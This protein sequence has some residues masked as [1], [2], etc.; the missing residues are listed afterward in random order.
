MAS[1][2]R[3]MQDRS[4]H[5]VAVTP[6]SAL[7]ASSRARVLHWI[8]RTG[9]PAAHFVT[10]SVMNPSSLLR[11]FARAHNSPVL[12]GRHAHP[13]GQ[14]VPESILLK[15]GRP[16]V[17]DIDDGLPFDNGR[18]PNH[19]R[20]WKPLVAKSRIA[21]R[22]AS[23]AD[24]VIAGN[25]RL[26]EWSSTR[27]SDVVLIP[28]CVEP[29]AYQQ[30]TDFAPRERKVI[31][32]IGSSATEVHLFGIADALNRAYERSPFRLEI[33]SSGDKPL[34]PGL[35]RFAYRIAWSQPTQHTIL[36]TWDA[37]LMPLPDHL[38]EQS[39]CA[40]KLL[41]YGAASIPAIGS[42]VGASKT[43]LEKAG[44]PTPRTSP[45]W[46]DALVDVLELPEAERRALG[47]QARTVVKIAYSY[48]AWE[49]RWLDAVGFGASTGLGTAI[50]DR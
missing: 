4:N 22:A 44:A 32:W 29:S 15:S 47:A 26:A 8:D 6:Y 20:W 3:E 19:G 33:V 38:Y 21:T 40:Y 49:S 41:Q 17:Y 9:I 34:P 10:G 2:Y 23:T 18:L 46:T 12:L 42:P 45:Q 35:S 24:R 27:C 25:E 28:T 7:D 36:A 30:R 1:V 48:A 43:F 13:L 11:A 5:L 14:G 37:G 16:G 31:G 50:Q 39:K